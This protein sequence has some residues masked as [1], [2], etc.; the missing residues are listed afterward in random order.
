MAEE[1]KDAHGEEAPKK[2]KLPLIIVG[3]VLVLLIVVG[4]VVFLVMSK[5]HEEGTDAAHGAKATE[6]A[7]PEKEKK[8]AHAGGDSAKV[9]PMF[10]LE[11]AFMTNLMSESGQAH[12]VKTKISL[13]MEAPEMQ[14]EAEEKKSVIRDIILNTLMS[15]TA[16]EIMTPRGKDTLKTEILDKLNER[17]KDGTF[18]NVYFEEFLIQ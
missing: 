13:E 18:K 16:E 3:V 17:M 9:G 1:A 2:S 12:F 11:G 8:K 15:K 5:G 7:E 4:V 6:H 10:P 14:K